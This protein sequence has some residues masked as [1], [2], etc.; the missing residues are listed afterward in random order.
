MPFDFVV[1]CLEGNL[2]SVISVD[3]ISFVS[4]MKSLDGFSTLDYKC[5]RRN[6]FS[7]C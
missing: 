6:Y 3:Y 5:L 4:S 7:G 1:Q 2:P